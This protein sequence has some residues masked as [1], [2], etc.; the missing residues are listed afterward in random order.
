MA[1][2][3]G[4]G[5]TRWLALGAHWICSWSKRIDVEKVFGIRAATA[6]TPVVENSLAKSQRHLADTPV[7]RS[8]GTLRVIATRSSPS[9]ST[10]PERERVRCATSVHYGQRN[11][12][13]WVTRDVLDLSAPPVGRTQDGPDCINASNAARAVRPVWKYIV[14]D[15]DTH[16]YNV[17]ITHPVYGFRAV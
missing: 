5:G 6:V 7:S 10:Q 2:M 17:G 1:E 16:P 15:H 8:D 11:Q 4:V 12:G 14:D 13:L 3:R 9:T